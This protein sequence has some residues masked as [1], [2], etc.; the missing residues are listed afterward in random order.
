MDASIPTQLKKGGDKPTERQRL[1]EDGQLP[2]CKRSPMNS[3]TCIAQEA[4]EASN[5]LVGDMATVHRPRGRQHSPHTHTHAEF[6]LSGTLPNP[7]KPLLI[8]LALKM[9]E[10]RGTFVAWNYASW[11]E[12][13][14]REEE[15]EERLPP[16]DESH[17]F[18]V[19]AL[20]LALLLH[21]Y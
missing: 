13:R 7:A 15:E 11:T 6:T 14:Q 4:E 2:Q 10:A 18:V 8:D 16:F 20:C 19:S 12:E 3:S 1:N 17:S 5:C 21:I 9:R